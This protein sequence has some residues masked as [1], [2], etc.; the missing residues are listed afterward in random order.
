MKARTGSVFMALTWFLQVNISAFFLSL[1][2]MYNICSPK[3]HLTTELAKVTDFLSIHVFFFCGWGRTMR[4]HVCPSCLLVCMLLMSC[5]VRFRRGF[6]MTAFDVSNLKWQEMMDKHMS[7]FSVFLF[8]FQFFFCFA[9]CS[10]SSS[11]K[12]SLCVY[13][14]M[15]SACIF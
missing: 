11:H 9:D 5:V 4:Q 8:S 14:I 7:T 12:V 6:W 2:S 10:T 15:A 1:F 13:F 3:S